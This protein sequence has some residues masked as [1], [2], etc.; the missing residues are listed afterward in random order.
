VHVRD[1]NATLLRLLGIDHEKLTFKFQGLE[2]KLT[3]VVPA[4][5]VADL[6]A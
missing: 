2:Q 3:G 6:M 5:V 1:F 4:T